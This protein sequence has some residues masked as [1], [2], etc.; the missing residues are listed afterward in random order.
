MQQGL[1]G[2]DVVMLVHG[3]EYHIRHSSTM[4]LRRPPG[5]TACSWEEDLGG[6]Q[7]LETV[8]ASETCAIVGML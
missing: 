8:E 1:V 2:C 7:G 3:G 5:A 6:S 4:G